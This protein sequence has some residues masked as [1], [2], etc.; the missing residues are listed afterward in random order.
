MKRF[1]KISLWILI[2]VFGLL[3]AAWVGVTV[4]YWDFFNLTKTEFI[5]PGLGDAGDRLFGT[6]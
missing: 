4:K 5:V 2:P 6:L 3:A 1:L